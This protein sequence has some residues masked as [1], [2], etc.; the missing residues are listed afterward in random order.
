MILFIHLLVGHLLGDFVFQTTKLSKLKMEKIRHLLLH[1]F[2]VFIALLITSLGFLSFRFVICLAIIAALHSIDYLKKYVKKNSVTFFLDQ[3]IHLSSL[4]LVPGAFGYFDLSKVYQLLLHLNNSKVIWVYVAGYIGGIFAGRIVVQ[5][6]ISE[7]IP[8]T[9]N[10]NNANVRNISAY[11]GMVE[12]LIVITL[13]ILNQYTAI[14]II[15]AIKG[16]ARKVFIE[17]SQ[18]NGEYYFL[19]TGLSFAIAMLTA[20]VINYLVSTGA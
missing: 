6:L 11:I 9:N 19:G 4:V 7:I 18:E 14:G 1:V 17:D 2:L 5:V 20:I 12:R 10:S 3:G 8:N 16:A 13:A 15:F